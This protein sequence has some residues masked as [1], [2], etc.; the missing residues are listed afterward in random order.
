M[1]SGHEFTSFCCVAMK[2]WSKHYFRLGVNESEDSFDS[3]LD[4]HQVRDLKFKFDRTLRGLFPMRNHVN[5]LSPGEYL[6]AI[7]DEN[8]VPKAQA[9]VMGWPSCYVSM[10]H[11]LVETGRKNLISGMTSWRKTVFKTDCCTQNQNTSLECHHSNC[12]S[13]SLEEVSFFMKTPF[14]FS[15]LDEKRRLL[16]V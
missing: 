1:V 11:F 15:I 9:S 6:Y 12:I 3:W 8:I 10:L 7:Y 14:D 2:T 4:Y 16:C 13:S 5:C